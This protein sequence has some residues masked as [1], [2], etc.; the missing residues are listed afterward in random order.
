MIKKL[1]IK[2]KD[3]IYLSCLSL[4]IF[5]VFSTSMHYPF[6]QWFDDNNYILCNKYLDFSIANIIHWF[7]HSCTG[8]YLPLTMLSY[9]FD[10]SLWGFNS[11][12]YHLQNIFW[13]IVATIAIYK[14]FRQFN[15]KSWI[16]F[17]LCMIF[18]IHPQRIESVVWLSERKDV[19][20]AAFYFLCLLF[21]IK[22]KKI[23]AFV[24]FILSILSK[25]MGLS[26]PFVLLLYEYYKHKKELLRAV[27]SKQTEIS[28]TKR[29]QPKKIPVIY[30]PG[31]KSTSN[32]AKTD[33]YSFGLIKL[34]PYFL[35]LLIFIPIS[36]IA[37]GGAAHSYYQ[38]LSFPRLYT[39]LYNIFWYFT[40]TVFPIELNPVYPYQ[41]YCTGLVEL[42]LFYAG[43]ILT[44]V[45]VLKRNRAFFMYSVLPLLLAFIISLLPVVGIVSLGS[46]DHADRYS[47][48][49]SVFIWFSI[50][51]ILNKLLYDRKFVGYRSTLKRNTT[52]LL[53][54]KFVFLILFLYSIALIVLNCFYQKTWKNNYTLF[55]HAA[56]YTSVNVSV[57]IALAD[58]E[59]KK[60]NY[61]K[62]LAIAEKLRQKNKDSSM[63]VFIEASVMYHLDKKAAIKLLLQAKPAFKQQSNPNHDWNIRY[64]RTLVMLIHSYYSIGEKQKTIDYIDELLLCKKLS[65]S[66]RHSMLGIKAECKKDLGQT[67]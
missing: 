4:I 30:Q 53:N 14:C 17:F 8:C 31:R 45:V 34:F 42:I 52:S 40:Q 3:I 19:L 61:E 7:T 1:K 37:Q 59:L 6:L 15:V 24:F 5:A 46:I 18:A 51:L 20:C 21:Y 11:F 28:N 26:L 9:M 41:T 22:E 44:V 54:T 66:T 16:A 62:A 39:V 29:Q 49:P 48:I 27:E 43:S 12:G 35:V 32:N 25:P 65:L 64:V 23:A 36:I 2:K 67:I 50:G 57:L 58:T 38:I 10:Y 33:G 60:G 56:N 47:Y 63:A 13:H 55:T